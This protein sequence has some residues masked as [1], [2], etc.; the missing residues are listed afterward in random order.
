MSLSVR[1]F[2]LELSRLTG[3]NSKRSHET[4]EVHDGNPAEEVCLVSYAETTTT[5]RRPDL[6]GSVHMPDRSVLSLRDQIKT[7]EEDELV[8]LHEAER[9]SCRAKQSLLAKH[10]KTSKQMS[11]KQ[12]FENDLI[13][14]EL[15]TQMTEQHARICEI[16]ALLREVRY[17]LREQEL[18][19]EREV[20]QRLLLEMQQ[21]GTGS[22]TEL[23]NRGDN[24]G[25]GLYYSPVRI[26]F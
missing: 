14:H 10:R 5:E 4:S 16:K 3:W 24:E 7:L 1:G 2:C 11:A 20:R 18:L 12:V 21:S 26:M 9:I 22:D 25:S 23:Q 8:A 15:Q 13:I 17:A 19:E 6:H